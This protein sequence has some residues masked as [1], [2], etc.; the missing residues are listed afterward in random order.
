MSLF[1]SQWVRFQVYL[2]DAVVT[3]VF[4]GFYYAENKGRQS[5]IKVIGS[6]TVGNVIAMGGTLTT[7]GGERAIVPTLFTSVIG[8][9]Y[10]IKPLGFTNKAIGGG[11]DGEL[12][13]VAGGAGVNNLG[14]LVRTTGLVK[15]VVT[16]RGPIDLVIDDGSLTPVTV[17][18]VT[19]TFAADD[20]VLVTG[21]ATVTVDGSVRSR[22]IRALTVE[23][24]Q[25]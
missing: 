17:L 18:G 1:L 11:T 24:I 22:A 15:N 14:L 10:S 6:S 13:G 23:K 2:K 8:Q 21:I 4:D 19:G 3:A 12:E 20:Y 9:G 7:D 16:D 5:A 25:R